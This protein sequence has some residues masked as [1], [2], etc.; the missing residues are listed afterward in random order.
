MSYKGNNFAY[1]TKH[2]NEYDENKI[3]Q[4]GRQILFMNT[5]RMSVIDFVKNGKSRC[6]RYN[7]AHK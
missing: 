3:C 1:F 5:V 6:Y 4:E 7:F 2:T